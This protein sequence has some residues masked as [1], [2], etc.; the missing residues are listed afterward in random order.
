MWVRILLIDPILGASLPGLI[1]TADGNLSVSCSDDNTEI[2][3]RSLVPIKSPLKGFG[4]KN[5]EILA[6]HQQITLKRFH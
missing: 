1:V 3:V 6:Y 2:L 5:T 4:A